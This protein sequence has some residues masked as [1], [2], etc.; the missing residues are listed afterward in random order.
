MIDGPHVKILT[1]EIGQGAEEA[2]GHK[3]GEDFE[4]FKENTLSLRLNILNKIGEDTDDEG[5]NG[6]GNPARFFF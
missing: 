6:H 4:D 3:H 2:Q 1:K 5:Q